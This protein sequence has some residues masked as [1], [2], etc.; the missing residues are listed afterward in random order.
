MNR[1]SQSAILLSDK[2]AGSWN[3]A[4]EVTALSYRISTQDLVNFW[5]GFKNT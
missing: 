1:L 2:R 5:K 4:G 3:D